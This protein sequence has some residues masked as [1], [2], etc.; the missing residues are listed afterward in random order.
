MDNRAVDDDVL[1]GHRAGYHGV[2]SLRHDR[3]PRNLFVP[4]YA[5]LNF[6]HI[7]DGTV[8]ARDVLFEPRNAPMELR[9]IDDTP[10][11]CTSHPRR[12]GAWRAA[13]GTSCWRTARSR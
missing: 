6:E 3:Q 8:Q 1:P 11:S 4:A 2:A 10:S 9:R 5:G 12:T 7:H 13:R